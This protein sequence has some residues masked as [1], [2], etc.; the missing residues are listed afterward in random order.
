MFVNGEVFVFVVE[1]RAAVAAGQRVGG[2]VGFGAKIQLAVARG[3]LA[4][5]EVPEREHQ[6]EAVIA[7][8]ETHAEA[9]QKTARQSGHF[10]G[11]VRQA[12]IEIAGEGSHRRDIGAN[13]DCTR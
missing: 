1:V 10:V 2:L 5:A 13:S 3:A 4:V 8:I 12:L 9:R 7:V 6:D 11:S